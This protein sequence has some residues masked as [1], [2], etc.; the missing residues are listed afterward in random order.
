MPWVIVLR[1]VVRLAAGLFFWRIAS[2]RRGGYTRAGAPPVRPPVPLRRID[3]RAALA[4]L[5]EGVSFG[6]RVVTAAVLLVFAVLLVDA[7]I[8]LVVLSPRWLGGLLLGVAVLALLAF[9]AEARAIWK[10]AARRRRR[11]HDDQLRGDV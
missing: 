11:L 10:V 8:T 5:R 3:P 7:G 6:W 2:A 1:W 4:A 9:N